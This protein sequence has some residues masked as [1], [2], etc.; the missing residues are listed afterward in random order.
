MLLEGAAVRVEWNRKLWEGCERL[1]KV[2]L[3]GAGGC[4]CQGG[5]IKVMC[6]LWSG[7]PQVCAKCASAA[8]CRYSGVPTLELL[9]SAAAGSCF[10]L[11]LQGTAVKL[12]YET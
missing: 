11:L 5:S 8:G 4:W 10:R 2:L 12:R 3:E 9:A 6:A 1:L 7:L